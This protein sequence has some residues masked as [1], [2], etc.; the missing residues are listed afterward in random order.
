MARKRRNWRAWERYVLYCTRRGQRRA[1]A[2]MKRYGAQRMLFHN[3]RVARQNAEFYSLVESLTGLDLA[4]L[5]ASAAS[6]SL[7]AVPPMLV[8]AGGQTDPDS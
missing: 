4:A 6:W 2:G 8:P 3:R 1:T 5:N 7:R